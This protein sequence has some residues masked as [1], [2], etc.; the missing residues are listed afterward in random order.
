MGKIIYLTRTIKMYA[1]CLFL[2]FFYLYNFEKSSETLALRRE[3]TKHVERTYR[4]IILITAN[5]SVRPLLYS[6]RNPYQFGKP[7]VYSMNIRCLW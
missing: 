2:V 3:N 1:S 7:A 5:M 6:V 4:I